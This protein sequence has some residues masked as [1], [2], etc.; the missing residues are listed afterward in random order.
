MLDLAYIICGGEFGS[1]FSVS[2][3]KYCAGRKGMPEIS[4]CSYALNE[5]L[6]WQGKSEMMELVTHLV[7][8][9]AIKII[10]T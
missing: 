5:C 1:T 3:N 4:T 8:F 10:I 6:K 7:P 9:L 2:H